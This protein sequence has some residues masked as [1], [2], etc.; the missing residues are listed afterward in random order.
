VLVL[1]TKPI[2]KSFTSCPL[3]ADKTVADLNDGTLLKATMEEVQGAD[4]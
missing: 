1:E 2:L 3:P 4:H